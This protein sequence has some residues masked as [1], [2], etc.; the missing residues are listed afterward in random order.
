RQ[1]GEP[2]RAGIGVVIGIGDDLARGRFQ[3]RIAGTGQPAVLGLDQSAVVFAR[4]NGRGVGGSVVH[5]DDLVV[6]VGEL[7][8][9]LHAV[10]NGARS[11][12]R[13]H[14]HRDSWPLQARRERHLGE[15]LSYRLQ[16]RLRRPVGAREAEGPV[17]YVVTLPIPLVG[18]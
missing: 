14:D 11:V 12:V 15:S 17:L 4:D 9:P 6:G 13:A 1:V 2:V 10:A 7:L 5:H 3:A 8:Q 18:P 16:G